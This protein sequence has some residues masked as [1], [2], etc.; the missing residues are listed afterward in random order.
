MSVT[1]YA[2][3]WQRRWVTPPL[4]KDPVYAPKGVYLEFHTLEEVRLG[5]ARRVCVSV[6]PGRTEVRALGGEERSV[7]WQ[8][9]RPT[10]VLGGLVTVHFV[11][12]RQV[13]PALGGR[14]TCISYVGIR[15]WGIENDLL[16][17]HRPA[18]K[19]EPPSV[20][21]GDEEEEEEEDLFKSN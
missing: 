8:L 6:T 18:R 2:A 17:D 20:Q 15:G 21:G 13:V 10:L 14:Y 9:P 1:A 3:W 7:V 12:K 19:H 4:A 5:G 11:G 16:G